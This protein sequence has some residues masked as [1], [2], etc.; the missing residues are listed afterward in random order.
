MKVARRLHVG[1]PLEDLLGLVRI[2]AV[3]ARERELRE[4]VR[5]RRVELAPREARGEQEA[6]GD[7][8]GALHQGSFR[9]AAGMRS[10]GVGASASDHAMTAAAAVA[11][12]RSF[13]TILSNVSLAVW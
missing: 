5:G 12:S 7:G 2:L 8:G 1:R 10:M 3:D 11:W 6:G 13:G 4:A 9:R